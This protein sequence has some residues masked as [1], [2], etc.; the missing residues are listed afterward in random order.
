MDR[1]VLQ[2]ITVVDVRDIP[3]GPPEDWLLDREVSLHCQND[4][5]QVEDDGNPF[6]EWLKENGYVF[7]YHNYE[8][9]NIDFDE[10]GILAT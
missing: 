10:I 4:I 3:Q 8:N 5:V 6:A 2:T 7:K 9:S 1:K